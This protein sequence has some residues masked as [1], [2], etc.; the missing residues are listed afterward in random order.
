MMNHKAEIVELI[1]KENVKLAKKLQKTKRE[2]N[3][4]KISKQIEKNIK[5]MYNFCI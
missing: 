4:E 3:R 5:T 1:S 2:S